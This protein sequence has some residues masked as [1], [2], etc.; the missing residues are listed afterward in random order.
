MSFLFST[1]QSPAQAPVSPNAPANPQPQQ[2]PT[3]VAQLSPRDRESL[4][5][6]VA[7]ELN[8]KGKESAHVGELDATL[9]ECR[10][11]LEAFERKE[12]SLELGIR[13]HQ[14]LMKR[15]DSRMQDLTKQIEGSQYPWDGL[16]YY[17]L[18]CYDQ[19]CGG[20]DDGASVVGGDD[21][22]TVGINT[23]DNLSDQLDAMQSKHAADQRMLSEV[24]D[25]HK[26]VIV[27]IG[28]FRRKIKDL[29]D[30]QLDMVMKRD[31]CEE[32]LKIAAWHLSK[33]DSVDKKASST[34]ATV[35]ITEQKSFGFLGF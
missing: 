30:R 21:D 6:D 26:E 33:I 11:S 31:E 9:K 27:Q 34:K 14:T 5:R 17:V 10:D 23:L 18:E 12:R 13:K 28:Q 35:A 4:I 7:L 20:D 22:Q 24:Q 25:M 3:S 15:R 8:R 29:E 32:F 19:G 16:V 2:S 1:F